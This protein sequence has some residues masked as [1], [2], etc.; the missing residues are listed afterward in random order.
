MSNQV[1]Y[2]Q[3]LKH[4]SGAY[5]R[6]DRGCLS[7]ELGVEDDPL[8]TIDYKRMHNRSVEQSFAGFVYC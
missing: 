4:D 3:Y 6:S 8:S 5:D 1:Y 7:L 2:I